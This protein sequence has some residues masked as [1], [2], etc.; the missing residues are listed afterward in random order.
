MTRSNHFIY[1]SQNVIDV[2]LENIDRGGFLTN[3]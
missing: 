3:K 2:E 1:A